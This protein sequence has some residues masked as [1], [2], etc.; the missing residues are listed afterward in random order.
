MYTAM[1]SPQPAHVA[2][3]SGTTAREGPVR[4]VIV[5]P[6]LGILGGQA[7]QAARLLERLERTPGLEVAFLAVN[8][9]LPGLLERLQR[10]KYVR[11]VVT[12]IAYLGDLATRLRQ[13]DV[14]HVFSAAYMSF[15][16]AP[17]PAM[18]IARALGKRVI[19]NYHSGEA[20]DH[21]QRWR[22]TVPRA[23]RLADVI[24]V[25]SRFLVE[26]FARFGLPAIAVPNFIEP[27]RYAARGPRPL[28]PTFLANRNFEAHYNVALV[29][30]A[31]ARIQQEIPEAT[32]V[33]AGDGPQRPAL[34]ALTQQ[35]GLRQVT[36]VGKVRPEDMPRLYAAADIYL[37]GSDIDNMPLSLI[38][39][40][41]SGVP[42]V[43]T[44]AG[45]IPVMVDHGRTG[46][47][48]ARGDASALADAAL[49]LLRDDRLAGRLITEGRR[50]VEQRYTWEAVGRQWDSLDRALAS[51]AAHPGHA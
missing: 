31:F 22:H 16:L 26:V 43:T 12:S 23:M 18:A 7:V 35:L 17:L 38:E 37:N 21:L 19:L 50:E 34:E 49:L 48:V 4:V 20:E 47:L 5:A 46:M 30:R 41:A 39:S 24:V 42:V 27:D 6:S 28:T 14:V 9:R 51:G 2:G 25:Q 8:P 32:L 15:V 10:I 3:F 29:L 1:T 36:F 40:F 45:G 13:A 33:V 44:D 11:T